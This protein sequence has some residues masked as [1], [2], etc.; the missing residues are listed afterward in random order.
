[1]R[2]RI[3]WLALLRNPSV[4]FGGFVLTALVIMAV[5]APLV[6]PGDPTAFTPRLRLKPPSDEFWFGTDR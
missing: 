4:A 3:P 2:G 5:A 1:M 6:A